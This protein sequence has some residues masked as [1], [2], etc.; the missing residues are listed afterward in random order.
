MRREPEPSRCRFKRLSSQHFSK[1]ADKSAMKLKPYLKSMMPKSALSTKQIVWASV[2]SFLF[3]C[4][5]LIFSES[6]L[7]RT[8]HYNI[9]TNIEFK[10]KGLLG[11]TPNLHKKIKILSLG[12]QSV[13]LLNRSHLF[14]HEW[15]HILEAIAKQ[16]PSKIMIDKIFGVAN[17]SKQAKQIGIEKISRIKTPIITGAFLSPGKIPKREPVDFS[18]LLRGMEQKL[19]IGLSYLN[20]HLFDDQ[21]GDEPYEG[22]NYLKE[23]SSSIAYARHSTLKRVFNIN[24]LF[25][26]DGQL[27][28][29]P[30][31]RVGEGFIFPHAS[32]LAA[33][34]ISINEHEQIVID[35]HILP[36]SHDGKS[37]IN[38]VNKQHFYS[39]I[40][41]LINMKKFPSIIEKGDIVL[42]LPNM[43]TGST[44]FHGSPMG[45]VPG[46]FFVVSVIN[47]ILTGQW[48]DQVSFPSIQM[49]LCSLLGVFAAVF[50][51]S[52][53]FWITLLSFLV[54]ILGGGISSFV[55]LDLETSWWWGS[56]CFL[57]ISI[58][59]FTYKSI[60]FE[61]FKEINDEITDILDSIEQA[62]FTFNP[63]LSMNSEYSKV[64]GELFDASFFK[65]KSS[66]D[67]LFSMDEKLSGEFAE[68]T[69]LLYKQKSLRKWKKLMLLCPM[70][71]M[72]IKQESGNKTIDLDYKPVMRNSQ[73]AKIMVLGTDVTSKLEIESKLKVAQ[74]SNQLKMER[75]HPFVSHD[76]ELIK[77]FL[78]ES[79]LLLKRYSGLETIQY[80]IEN[81]DV[82]YRDMHTLKGNAGSFGFLNLAK[83]FDRAEDFMSRIRDAK[84]E[85]SIDDDLS[86]DAWNEKV[87]EVRKEIVAI[88]H[89]R[90]T[91]FKG[92]QGK[93][94]VDRKQYED[95]VA[96]VEKNQISDAQ[97]LEELRRLS[98][99]PFGKLMEKYTQ[100]IRTYREKSEKDIDDLVVLNA[101]HLMDKKRFAIFD[102]ALIHLI[103]NAMDHGIEDQV[104]RAMANKGPGSI[105]VSIN[106]SPDKEEIIIRDDG[107]G[108]DADVIYQKALEKNLIDPSKEYTEQEKVNLICLPGFSTKD[109]ANE[110]SGRGVGMDAVNKLLQDLGGGLYIESEKG[111]GSSFYIHLPR[112]IA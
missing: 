76:L 42:I 47:S 51:S 97:I 35:G 48:I 24:G 109:E 73:L 98:F 59:V 105:E 65:E 45:Y 33:S 90:E 44:D 110:I 36:I 23:D 11:K 87:E 25:N 49:F 93:L 26:Y 15:A 62:I 4:G 91:L 84:N 31:V 29:S 67:K 30:F 50:L 10:L 55:Y 78:L 112:E 39:R 53:I 56:I 64:A 43:Y 54:I 89:I 1:Q 40:K 69:K 2:L 46:G 14:L 32:M 60:F 27:K 71:R 58:V 96:K 34:E 99:T 92:F 86:L 52:S 66:I 101:E 107:G 22:L 28:Y 104:V 21:E 6:E 106:S 61:K 108:I 16:E 72:E 18:S 68:W 111:K 102:K 80:L 95:L 88:E 81:I 77:E 17:L 79:A 70:K 8:F 94:S 103:R 3:Y 5:V 19:G 74:K 7:G 13:S 9:A 75:M 63:D 83:I 37:M 20:P 82:A 100:L 41:P 57:S 85:T 38:M 12:D